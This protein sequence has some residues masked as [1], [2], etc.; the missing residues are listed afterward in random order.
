VKRA[1]LSRHAIAPCLHDTVSPNR[2][3]K[4][5]GIWNWFAFLHRGQARGRRGTPSQQFVES[6][7]NLSGK[8]PARCLP[9][10]SRQAGRPQE[11]DSSSSLRARRRNA[12]II[13]D[14]IDGPP[15]KLDLRLNTWLTSSARISSLNR[16][17]V[18]FG[19]EGEGGWGGGRIPPC[20][21]NGA[22]GR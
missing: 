4:L 19:G 7:R 15:S 18:S 8:G 22:S 16:R 2:P 11:S 3:V 1:P 10:L 21:I 12:S 9:D 5:P 6:V 17:L 13:V 20:G 14:R